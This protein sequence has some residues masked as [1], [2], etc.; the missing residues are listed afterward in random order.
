M[1][2][3]E[4]TNARCCQFVSDQPAEAADA[5]DHHAGGFELALARFTKA[6][7]GGL[8]RVNLLLEG[9]EFGQCAVVGHRVYVLPAS[10]QQHDL[11]LVA[12]DLAIFHLEMTARQASG[13]AG[14]VGNV[15]DGDTGFSVDVFEEA[16]HFFVELFVEAA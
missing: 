7:D 12:H 5:A 16:T 8:P 1:G 3:D 9:S 4:L 15:E 13:F 2:K 14:A 11:R 6:F 10:C